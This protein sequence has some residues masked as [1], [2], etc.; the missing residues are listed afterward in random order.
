MVDHVPTNHFPLHLFFERLSR[1]GIAVSIRDYRRVG[2]VLATDGEWTL[3]R[4]ERVLG[5]LLVHDRDDRL[6]FQHEFRT[7]FAASE[8]DSVAVDVRQWRDDIARL[9]ADGVASLP[10]AEETPSNSPLSGGEPQ[11]TS[12]SSAGSSPDKGRLGG[13]SSWWLVIG[14]IL[15]LA[16]AAFTAWKY[17]SADSTLPTPQQPDLPVTTQT[18]TLNGKPP[19]SDM[20]KVQVAQQ[21]VEPAT[22]KRILPELWLPGAVLAAL[23][24]AGLLGVWWTQYRPP[25]IRK[26]IPCDPTLPAQYFDDASV[27]GA[28]PPWLAETDADHL[29]DQLS[30][31]LTDQYTRELDIPASIRA[32]SESGSVPVLRFQKRRDLQRVLILTDQLVPQQGW[33]QLPA[34]LMQALQVRGVHL[35]FGRFNYSPERFIDQHGRA[36]RLED[37]EEYRH[38]LLLLIF[39]DTHQ[40]EGLQE[41]PLAG[42][43]GCAA[44][45]AAGAA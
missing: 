25:N 37:W 44:A 30:Y 4:L 38:H 34:E 27:G 5:N 12:A 36:Q 7:F 8:G 19:I 28:I 35:T 20:R 11:I 21:S 17:Y 2:R 10:L 9:L 24:A 39:A 33:H 6:L 26:K 23:L 45:D 31:T 14:T 18:D 16:I 40:A 41:F 22:D 32:T 3:Q 29:T 42:L 15:I 13:V 1:A 43:A